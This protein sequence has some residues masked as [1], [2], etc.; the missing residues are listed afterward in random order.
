M[1]LHFEPDS[2]LKNGFLCV[3]LS[4]VLA[5]ALQNRLDRSLVVLLFEFLF[6]CHTLLLMGLKV[7]FSLQSLA[8]VRNMLLRLKHVVNVNQRKVLSSFPIDAFGI[9]EPDCICERGMPGPIGF[10]EVLVDLVCRMQGLTELSEWNHLP[11]LEQLSSEL[12][13]ELSLD[14][15]HRWVGFLFDFVTDYPL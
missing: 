10:S 14:C 8:Q 9:G 1:I 6:L 13:V 3:L 4:L 2:R 5:R 11:R 15:R 7:V 12:R